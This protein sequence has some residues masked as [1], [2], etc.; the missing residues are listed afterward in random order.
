MAILPALATQFQSFFPVTDH[1]QARWRWF[2]LTLQAILVSISASRTSSLRRTIAT[3]FG[4]VIAPSRYYTFM[5]SVKL[6]WGPV[7]E[8][9]WRAIPAPLTGGRLLAVDDSINPKTGRKVVAC[10]DTFDHAAKTNQSQF[11]CAQTSC[12]NRCGRP[13]GRVRTCCRAYAAMPPCMSC[14]PRAPG[15]RGDHARMGSARAPPHNWLPHS[16]PRPSATRFI[17]M[18]GCA[19]WWPSN[20]EHLAKAPPRR[21]AATK[22]TEY[23][24]AGLRRRRLAQDLGG[25]GFGID[26]ADPG[27]PAQ[28]PLLAAVVALVA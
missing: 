2:M 1:G 3:L 18:G 23:A 17:C 15:G 12:S 5:A 13:S 9:R 20:G 6:A 24:F 8:V 11:P 14:R 28:N 25:E 27:K 21:Y 16:A 7:W 19:W 22:R 10:Q 4:V 26:C